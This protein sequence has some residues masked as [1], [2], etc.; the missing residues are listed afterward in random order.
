MSVFKRKN[1][2]GEDRWSYRVTVR[3]PN[4][5]TERI[6]GVPT[7][8]TKAAAEDAER[9]HIQRVLHPA[10][11]AAT[12]APE[13]PTFEAFANEWLATYP[14]S[15]GNR[16]STAEAHEG[17][18]RVHLIPI[19][20]DTRLDKIDAQVVA[21][22]F[23]TLSETKNGTITKAAAAKVLSSTTIRNVGATLHKMLISASEWGK[24]PQ[25]IP[26]WPKR[27]IA[28]ADWDF[29][30]KEE[31]A[32]LMEAAKKETVEAQ[33]AILFA[34]RTGA[35]AGEL[36]ALEWGDLDFASHA[37][38]I[39]RSIHEGVENATKTGKG[40]VVPLS[41][42]LEGLLK[43]IRH[44]RGA[45]VFCDAEGKP[46]KLG[47]LDHILKRVQRRAGLRQ[48]RWHDLR[49]S[50]ASQ[51]MIA[52]VQIKQVQEWLGHSTITMTMRYAHLAPNAN[53]VELVA[54]LDG[55]VG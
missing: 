14:K 3:L 15:A 12:P 37:V 33:A 23:A 39:R 44:L 47:Q 51:C 50:F 10:A 5:G 43:Q 40:R 45:K 52:G 21:K 19:L 9:D 54:L 18:C 53:K 1:T 28:H 49:H 13:S 26:P 41:P 30:V 31:S 35:R 6:S 46:L 20:G 25:G 11:P 38:H 34:L 4:G 55:A 24:L 16:P 22:V 7:I 2:A 36:L 48:I 32:R 42:E 17:H 29:Y 8:N 27:K